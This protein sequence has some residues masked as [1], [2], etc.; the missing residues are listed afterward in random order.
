M[1]QFEV[2]LAG[3]GIAMALSGVPALATTYAPD[4][5]V[6]DA[7]PFVVDGRKWGDPTL[8]TPGGNVTYSFMP[9]GTDCS[10]EFAGCTVTAFDDF[11]PTGWEAEVAAAFDAW[12]DIA[13]I[14]FSKVA[15][16]GAPFNSPTDSGDIRIGGHEFDGAGGTLA[17]GFFPPPNGNTAAGD[18]HFDTAETWKIGF[19]GS[20]FDLFQ[21]MAHEIGHAIGLKHE[22]T[23]T[24]LMNPFYTEDFRGLLQDDID[25][26]QEIYGPAVIPLPAT[27]PL[28]A[29]GLGMLGLMGRWRRRQPDAT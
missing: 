20:G 6:P 14:S 7:E 29:A 15:D 3:A 9:T 28:A 12:A 19:G 4:V 10:A 2:I 17:H 27:L 22:T 8:G 5:M 16:D 21:V 24:A 23:V 11:M 1:R 18:I 26:A 13:D 25:G